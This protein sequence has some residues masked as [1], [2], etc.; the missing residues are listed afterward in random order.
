MKKYFIKVSNSSKA[1]GFNRTITVYTQNKDGSFNFVGDN[2]K[3]NM[4]SYRGDTAVASKILHDKYNYKWS[5][6][7]MNYTLMSKNIKL[8][9]LP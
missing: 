8:I 1:R 6:K 2:E 4:A 5:L 7:D 3:I 9:F